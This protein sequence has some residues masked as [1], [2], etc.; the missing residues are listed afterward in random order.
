MA[1]VVVIHIVVMVNV[2]EMKILPPAQKIV[3]HQESVKV[4]Y[5]YPLAIL[6]NL[7]VQ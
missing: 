6:M 1:Q 7:V 3:K 4:M 5:V 2:M